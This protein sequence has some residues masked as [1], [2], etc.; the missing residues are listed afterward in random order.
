MRAT[1]TVALLLPLLCAGAQAHAQQAAPPPERQF[2]GKVAQPAV[3]DQVLLLEDVDSG[4]LV[5]FRLEPATRFEDPALPSARALAP[6]REVRV[7]FLRRG[8]LNVARRV[9]PGGAEATGGAGGSAPVPQHPAPSTPPPGTG[10]SGTPD[11]PGTR[12]VPP[13][14]DTDVPEELRPERPEPFPAELPPGGGAP[15]DVLPDGRPRAQRR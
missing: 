8:T 1:L 15:G 10:G 11:E 12:G 2:V 9:A 14:G 4:A 3:R 6:G 7:T 5:A 13:H